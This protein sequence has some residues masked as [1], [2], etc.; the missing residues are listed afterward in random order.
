[1]G[2]FSKIFGT[3]SD[4]QIKK[5]VP[6]VDKIEALSDEYASKTDLE[7]REKTTEFKK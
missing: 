6:I 3:Y 4:R 5:I 1:M 7:L 2:I